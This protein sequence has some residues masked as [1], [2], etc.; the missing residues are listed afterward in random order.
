MIKLGLYQHYKGNMYF[1]H[2]IARH[3]ENHEIFVMYQALYGGYNMWIRPFTMF[4]EIIIIDGIEQ[5]RFKFIKET[6]TE[7]ASL[8]TR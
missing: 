6:V 7:V 4:T 2:G 3:S 1:I 5:P 8:E